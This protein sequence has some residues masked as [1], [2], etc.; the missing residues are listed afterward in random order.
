MVTKE[1]ISKMSKIARISVTDEE[2]LEFTEDINDI[3][4]FV[5]TKD[6][7][8]YKS[9]EFCSLHGLENVFRED[10]EVESLT[11][12]EVLQNT[13]GINAPF[14]SVESNITGG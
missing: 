2:L 4:R 10:E 5:D 13:N 8:V 9:D 12:E 1:E 3:L 6:E 7:L 11:V 14:F